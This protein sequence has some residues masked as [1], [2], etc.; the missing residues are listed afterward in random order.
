MSAFSF[1]LKLVGLLSL[2]VFLAIVGILQLRPA[3]DGKAYLT[4]IHLKIHKLAA[5]S[6][7]EEGLDAAKLDLESADSTVLRSLTQLKSYDYTSTNTKQVELLEQNILA[8]LHELFLL[9]KSCIQSLQSAENS[10]MEASVLA[11]GG[12]PVASIAGSH[13]ESNMEAAKAAAAQAAAA[14][15]ARKLA[16]ESDVS[17]RRELFARGARS[18]WTENSKRI[19]S[20]ILGDLV[21]LDRLV[22]TS[23]L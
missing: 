5:L 7:L 14:A 19:K 9:K 12:E 10:K 23:V 16:M 15:A 17:R 8:R 3:A 21:L 6:L 1:L 11:G 2:V 20:Q 22:A 4:E 18:R 13:G